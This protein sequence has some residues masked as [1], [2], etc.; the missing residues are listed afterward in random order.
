M[1]WVVSVRNYV[2]VF[3]SISCR[4]VLVIGISG[5]AWSCFLVLFKAWVLWTRHDY[6]WRHR[7]GGAFPSGRLSATILAGRE[8]RR[9][10][11]IWIYCCLK[12]WI[13]PPCLVS[14]CLVLLTDIFVLMIV[15]GR[16]APPLQNMST[17]QVRLFH[18]TRQPTNH[19]RDWYTSSTPVEDYTLLMNEHGLK[20]C[21]GVH[22]RLPS[23]YSSISSS[24]SWPLPSHTREINSSSS[25]LQ[26]STREN[27]PG[28][29]VGPFGFI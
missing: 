14:C 17:E 2:F 27:A 21:L 5:I 4:F 16:V 24:P 15:K 18:Q 20:A 26:C 13:Y 23:C 7:G 19:P 22:V 8:V 12:S 3:F 1:K 9:I 11:S 25:V 10:G 28:P 29:K 6:F